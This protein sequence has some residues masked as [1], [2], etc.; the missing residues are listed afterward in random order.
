MGEGPLTG[1]QVN[2]LKFSI[3]ASNVQKVCSK[4]SAVDSV[5][6]NRHA[7]TVDI[8]VDGEDTDLAT[9]GACKKQVASS[10]GE[11]VL[12]VESSIG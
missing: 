12:A 6:T 7:G 1:S 8:V 2:F 11:V 9:G 10:L 5:R 4:S 3:A